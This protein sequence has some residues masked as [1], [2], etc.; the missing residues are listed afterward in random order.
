MPITAARI[1][2]LA[3]NAL[4]GIMVGMAKAAREPAAIDLIAFRLE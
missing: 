2:S 3:P 4:E 1:R